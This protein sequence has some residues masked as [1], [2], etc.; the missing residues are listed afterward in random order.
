MLSLS[1]IDRM[2]HHVKAVNT[3]VDKLMSKVVPSTPV[4]GACSSGYIY[5][6]DTQQGYECWA[7]S[8]CGTNKCVKVYTRTYYYNGAPYTCQQLFKICNSRN[9]IGTA[10]CAGSG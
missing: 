10:E 8:S 1:S 3:L 7:S 2:L 4:A 9:C 6:S 5:Y